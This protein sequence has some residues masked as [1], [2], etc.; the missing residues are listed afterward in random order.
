MGACCG[1]GQITDNPNQSESELALQTGV[2]SPPLPDTGE[3]RQTTSS[4]IA[5]ILSFKKQETNNKKTIKKLKTNYYIQ[6][7]IV[8]HKQRKVDGEFVD[9]DDNKFVRYDDNPCKLTDHPNELIPPF[10]KP[11]LGEW[12]WL[13][14]KWK[15]G[16]FEKINRNS[17]QKKYTRVAI[18]ERDFDTNVNIIYYI[19]YIL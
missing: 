2:N 3:G 18:F 6:V 16:K 5:K 7:V 19:I 4:S 11:T 13:E 10:D 14:K 1:G 15:E 9:I 12:K 17:Q 8:Y